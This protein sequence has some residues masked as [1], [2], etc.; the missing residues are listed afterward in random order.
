MTALA[1]PLLHDP[2]QMQS[3][4]RDLFSRKL[5]PQH[6]GMGAGF[7]DIVGDTVWDAITGLNDAMEG[8]LTAAIN[9]VKQ[10][11]ET[12]ALIVRACIGD[13]PW[14]SVLG[15]LGEVFQ[16]VGAVLYYMNPARIAYNWLST[17]P[18]TAHAFAELDKF[19]G[20]MITTAVN[21][22]DLP[23][24]AMRGDPI[25]TVELIRDALLVI[26]IAA[27]VFSGGTYLMIGGIIGTMVGR[28]V[29]GHQTEAKEACMMAF[30]IAGA[31][32]GS[33]GDSVAGAASA[34]MT[35]AEENA[36]LNG[37]DA[38]ANYLDQ[39]VEGHLQYAGQKFLTDQGISVISQGA[40]KMC[41]KGKWVGSN[42]CKIMGEV[43]TDYLQNGTDE[44]FSDFL[45][46]EIAKIGAEQLMLQWFP[47][48]SKEHQAIQRQW[49]LRY[50]DEPQAADVNQGQVNP[51]TFLLLAAGAA[52]VLIGA[53][54]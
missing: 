34:E 27:V 42:E 10:I 44:D 31:A 33:W 24:R 54:S 48:K 26:E 30:Q 7:F 23:A 11:G 3:L 36:W 12:L 22:S 43:V 35:D 46:T 38:Y 21:L 5:K 41:Q 28:Q 6:L 14:S 13:V 39:S 17:A 15:S 37:D 16:G 1:H 50:V 29:C 8:A 2:F 49:T 53:G 4:K 32:V 19:T 9:T 47:P 18:L 20:G 51:F 25:S 52:A 45:A 40:I